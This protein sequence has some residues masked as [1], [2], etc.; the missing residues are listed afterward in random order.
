MIQTFISFIVV[1]GIIV[2]IHEM[3]HFFTARYFGVTVHEFAIGMGPA[4]FKRTGKDNI[5]Y[6]VRALPLGG[7]VRMEGED[8]SSDDPNA[9]SRK[10]PYQRL[11]V[12]AA[13]AFMN[14]VLAFVL[15]F[16]VVVIIGSPSTEIEQVVANF[17]ASE[18]GLSAGDRILSINNESVESWNEL[19]NQIHMSGGK[20]L[21][22]EVRRASSNEVERL[23][24]NPV[25]GEGGY[26]QIGITPSY[27][28]NIIQSASISLEQMGNVFKE[29]YRFITRQLPDEVE[30][31]LVG[32]VGIVKMIGEQSRLGLMNL[33]LFAAMISI[34]LGI[35][36][37]LPFP[38]LDGGRIIF[39]LIEMIKGSPVDPEKEGM[40]HMVG[41]IIL[42]SLMVFLVF[43]DV[44]NLRT[45]QNFIETLAPYL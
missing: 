21:D 35:F 8:E 17:P 15:I 9:F 10:K 12:L 42:L 6:T 25:Q 3:G 31:E 40:V 1:F 13:G 27:E 32:P 14:F 38:A 19:V 39:I 24:I 7:F 28:R 5:L 23:A 34:N 43:R 20:T 18:A 41:I 22:V 30:A 2:M 11:I 26:Y 37:L 16:A 33:T 36:N 45:S 29:L 4:I 44:N